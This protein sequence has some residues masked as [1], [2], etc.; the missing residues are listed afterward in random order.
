M[1]LAAAF[2]WGVSYLSFTANHSGIMLGMNS[3]HVPSLW[4]SM[5]IE[6][7]TYSFAAIGAAFAL[8]SGFI[9]F[10]NALRNF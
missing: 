3:S 6:P 7:A 4:E 8:G 5:V 1:L 9:L 2:S 10:R